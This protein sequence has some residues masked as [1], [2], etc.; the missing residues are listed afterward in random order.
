MIK[1][2]N[3][4][5]GI[6]RN[7]EHFLVALFFF[8]LI[9]NILFGERLPVE[10]GLGWD[11]LLYADMVK[12]FA[13]LVFHHQLDEYYIQRIIP[14]GMVRLI[15]TIIGG[16][17]TDD[18]IVLA[19]SIYNT[20]ILGIAVLMWKGI[21]K[22]LVWSPQV[23]LISF[24]GLF[25]NFAILKMNAYYPA[26][27]DT[28]AFVISLVML[29]FF[30]AEKPYCLL[31]T[32]IVGAFIF[33]TTIYVGLTLFVFSRPVLTGNSYCKQTFSYIS[34]LFSFLTAGIIVAAIYNLYAIAGNIYHCTLG[35]YFDSPIVYVSLFT[36][37]L[38][39]FLA[40]FP[41][42]NQ[43]QNISFKLIKQALNYR[44]LM[45]ILV[46]VGVKLLF[47]MLSNSNPVGLLSTGPIIKAIAIRSIA[48]P[49]ISPISHVVFFG[50]II[51]LLMYF[52]KDI[53]NN[54]KD[55]ESG[56]LVIVLF[57]IFLSMN[58]ESREL[59][60]FLPVVVIVVAEVL[61]RKSISWNFSYLFVLLSLV[62]SKA[63]LPINHGVW[64]KASAAATLQFPMQWY[65]MNYGPWVSH[66]MYFINTL[67]V[68]SLFLILCLLV[69]MQITSIPSGRETLAAK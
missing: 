10:H 11:G 42:Y 23:R 53:I 17:L 1:S 7:I 57:L 45:A 21:A 62:E 33:P 2:T 52:W 4:N 55:K 3:Q 40:F 54:L 36:S 24:A 56:L 59:I 18:K 32:T 28:S 67:I 22:K 41:L 15:A 30:I 51:C 46:F 66:Q 49:G 39:F 44:L 12:N 31:G 9:A 19:F 65:F 8:W 68:V 38:F 60:N 37:F 6:H 16:S 26:L 5:L 58:S 47:K 20:L 63:W 50:P 35:N 64:E 34:I 14:S 48:Y 25:L 27:T 13:N 29:Y 61:N 69:K 43:H